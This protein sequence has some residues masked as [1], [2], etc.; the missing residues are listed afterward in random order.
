MAPKRI[1]FVAE[2]SLE[3]ESAVAAKGYAVTRVADVDGAL[4]ELSHRHFDLVLLDSPPTLWVQPAALQKLA[5]AAPHTPILKCSGPESL[6][7]ALDFLN[8]STTAGPAVP[9]GRVR[10]MLYGVTRGIAR[11]LNSTL[12]PILGNAELLLQQATRA[13]DR[14]MLQ[15][16]VDASLEAQRL[17]MR[18]QELPAAASGEERAEVDINELLRHVV[19]VTEPWWR[20]DLRREGRDIEVTLDLGPA[21][22]LQGDA[23]ALQDVFLQLLLNAIEAIAAQGRV[24]I[25][26]EHT[27]T[28]IRVMFIDNGIGVPRELQPLLFQPFITSKGPQRAGLGLSTVQ[29]VLA[30]HNGSIEIFSK[31]REG[32]TVVVRLPHAAAGRDAQQA[33]AMCE[34]S[35][36]PIG[37]HNILI[38]ED[39]D[40][41]RHLLKTVLEKAGQQVTAV[42]SPEEGLAAFRR[43]SYDVVF[44]GWGKDGLSGLQAAQ[45]VKEMSPPTRLILIT[46]WGTQV[47]T[48]QVFTWCVDAILTLPFTINQVRRRLREVLA[49]HTQ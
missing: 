17:V 16:I 48:R 33:D 5:D 8:H 24:E 41:V 18:L 3:T 11:H 19:E 14:R 10:R 46:G 34:E 42:A 38:I 40:Q 27:A 36:E 49:S 28:E 43:G 2:T 32:T 39:E 1:L 23:A 22:L 4:T 9:E 6:A 13:E 12:T 35:E 30:E 7:A 37:L 31:E 47:N 29:A 45:K 25:K 15:E 20:H 21:C 26:T 44:T